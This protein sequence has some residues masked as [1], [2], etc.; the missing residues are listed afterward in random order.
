MALSII[1]LVA[2]LSFSVF[3]SE[4]RAEKKNSLFEDENSSTEPY[5]N[6]VSDPTVAFLLGETNL[7]SNDKAPAA[8]KLAPK[9]GNGH[10]KDADPIGGIFFLGRS[11]D[12]RNRKPGGRR[13]PP[14]QKPRRE[15]KRHARSPI[16]PGEPGIFSKNQ[17]PN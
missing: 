13:N 11:N 7:G 14:R 15:S 12:V 1:A 5:R 2:L 6:S 10:K 9:P 17:A 4:T 16:K 8:L 3:L